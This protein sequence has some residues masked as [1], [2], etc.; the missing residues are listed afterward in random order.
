MGGVFHMQVSRHQHLR[1]V[2]QGLAAAAL[3]GLSTPL[4]KILV[5]QISPLLLAGM[6]YAGSGIGLSIWMLIRRVA[7]RPSAETSLARTD[8][9][10]LAGAVAFGGV[11][12]P[13]LLMVGLSSMDG[14]TSSLLLNLEAVLTALIAWVVFR[15]NFDRRIALGMLAIVAGGVLLAWRPHAGAMIPLGAA[16][17]AGACLCWGIDNNLTRAVSGGDPVQIAAIKGVVAGVINIAAALLVGHRF[18]GV[19][20]TLA[21]GIVGF[22]GYGLSLVLFVL[23][24]R[25][26]GTARTGAY[27]STAPFLGAGVSLVLFA[28]QPSLLFWCAGALMAVGI[29]LHLAERHEHVHVHET[30]THDHRHVH[31]EHHQHEHDFPWDGK[32]PHA[33]PHRHAPLV[34]SHAH[35]PDL[36]HRHGNDHGPGKGG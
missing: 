24:L 7:G 25:S 12:A 32:G 1:G 2:F 27:F 16:A 31:D 10:W 21:T 14:A 26:L 36:H 5:G 28:E 23:A 11:L 13:I 4:A 29:W 35:Y 30:M 33:H 34:H 15:E 19:L 3:F 6:L 20:V 9:P 8:L 22:V 18:P 17:I